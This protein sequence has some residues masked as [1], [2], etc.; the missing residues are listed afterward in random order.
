[1]LVHSLAAVL[2]GALLDRL[3]PRIVFPAAACVVALG[4]LAT[5]RMTALWQ[6]YLW[7]GV[8]TPVGVCAI[9]FI[10]HSMVLP[11]WFQRKRGLAIG[12]AMAGV[13]LGMQI[14]V[15]A[16]QLS[17]PA[18]AGVRPRGPGGPHPRRPDPHEPAPPATGPQSLGEDP[19]GF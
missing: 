7:Y 3:G 8:F 15:P 17:S 2:I 5:S 4:L 12:I 18:T 13:G 16:T 6:F 14:F 19:T 10:A 9:G 1:M 11:K